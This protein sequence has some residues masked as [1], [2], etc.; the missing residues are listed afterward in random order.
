MTA[1][2]NI[3]IKMTSAVPQKLEINT[4]KQN[5]INKNYEIRAPLFKNMWNV[6]NYLNHTNL[7]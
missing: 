4:F 6:V 2:K 5:Q 3:S 7:V 1:R